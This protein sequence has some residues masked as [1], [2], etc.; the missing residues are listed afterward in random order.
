MAKKIKIGWCID[1]PEHTVVFEE[2]KRVILDKDQ[3]INKK[4]FL[5]CPAVRSYFDNT[6]YVASP[7][8]IKI[9]F[10]EKQNHF[11]IHP[12]YPFTSIDE[13]KFTNLITLEH[14]SSWK[15]NHTPIIQIPSPY[16]F[17]ADEDISIEQSSPLIL[18]QSKINWSTEGDKIKNLVI[19][20]MEKDLLPDLRK[21]IVE[22]K[23]V[24]PDYFEQELSTKHGSGFSIQP[25]FTQSA[26]FRFHNK[27]EVC[28]NLYFVGAG[29][30]PGA[31]VPGVLSSA[32]VLDKIL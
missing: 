19:D 25:K 24:T 18:N 27:S 26:Y 10:V 17:F 6:F 8:S 16:V 30:H 12:I 11:Q 4:N 5:S 13:K 21:N 31:G 7:Y 23:Y 15:N 14:F 2:P 9:K 22:E 29:T 32:K 28:D 1:S 3:S 20:K